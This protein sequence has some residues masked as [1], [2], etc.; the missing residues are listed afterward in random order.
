[1]SNITKYKNIMKQ[2]EKIASAENSNAISV[3]LCLRTSLKSDKE[4]ILGF[5]L[6]DY[7]RKPLLVIPHAGIVNITPRAPPH[8]DAAKECPPF[9]PLCH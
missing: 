9:Q 1:M 2:I 8:R 7:S 3:P 4:R 6:P 5:I